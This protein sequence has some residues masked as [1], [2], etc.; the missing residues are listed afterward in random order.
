MVEAVRRPRTAMR[1]EREENPCQSTPII[2]LRLGFERR[3]SP[4]G[5]PCA[6]AL[7]RAIYR[8]SDPLCSQRGRGFG[9]TAAT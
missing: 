6:M 7:G 5:P 8:P 3:H 2:V 1:R 4:N 9:V